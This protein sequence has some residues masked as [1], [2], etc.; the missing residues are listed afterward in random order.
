[1][2][3]R[4]RERERQTD[5]ERETDRER[6]RQRDRQTDRD[7]DKERQ[8]QRE[9]ERWNRDRHRKR[10]RLRELTFYGTLT[11]HENMHH[12]Q[13]HNL[14]GMHPNCPSHTCAAVTMSNDLHVGCNWEQEPRGRVMSS[15]AMSPA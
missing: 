3:E 12:G 11:T 1:M 14:P 6:Q 4:E 10:E 5:R 13:F 7:R 9:T 2:R 15:S 8:R